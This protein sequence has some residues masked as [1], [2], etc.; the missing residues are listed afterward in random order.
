[1]FYETETYLFWIWQK[2]IVMSGP[3]IE[4]SHKVSRNSILQQQD[5]WMS[6]VRWIFKSIYVYIF[7]A[8]QFVP[9]FD[10]I[11]CEK[12]PRSRD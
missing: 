8:L 6:P 12:D 4:K 1:M 7:S 11:L 9:E 2:I 3:G 5:G 10:Y